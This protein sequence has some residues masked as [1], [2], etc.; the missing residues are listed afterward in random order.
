[1]KM[2]NTSSNHLIRHI[3]ET[4]LERLGMRLDHA[5]HLKIIKN[6]YPAILSMKQHALRNFS[7]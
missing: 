2:I 4:I 5:R 1:M 7:K 3:P 6:L